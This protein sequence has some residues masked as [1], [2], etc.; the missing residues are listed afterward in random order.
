MGKILLSLLPFLIEMRPQEQN[1]SGADLVHA[2]EKASKEFKRT[3]YSVIAMLT[4]SLIACGLTIFAGIRLIQKLE[5]FVRPYVYGE[6]WLTAGY[7]AIV[8]TSAGL[9]IYLFTEKLYKKPVSEKSAGALQGTGIESIVHSLMQG[10]HDGLA[11]THRTHE[12]F[13]SK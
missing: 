2:I 7:S 4:T 1:S 5:S 3:L 10:F 6:V 12:Q 9:L 11:K 8:L 13:S